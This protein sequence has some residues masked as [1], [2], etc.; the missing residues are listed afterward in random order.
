MA[1]E[2]LSDPQERAW[3]DSHRD[4]ILTGGSGTPDLHEYNVRVT[5]THDVLSFLRRSNGEIEFSDS[6][7]GFYGALRDFFATLARE[8]ESICQLADLRCPSYPSFGHADASYA[9]RVRAFYSFWTGFATNKS[10]SWKDLYRLS[11]APDRRV[12]RL[13]EKENKRTRDEAVREFNDAVRSL[14]AFAKKRDPRVPAS[15]ESEFDR[16]K[17]LR[18]ATVAQAIRSKLA[19]QAKISPINTIPD[20]TK[21]SEPADDEFSEEDFVSAAK[22][23]IECVICRKSFKSEKQ[24][25]AHER[26]KKVRVIRG[27]FFAEKYV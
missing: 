7:T 10:F 19:N 2:L 11:D 13:M 3:Y 23:I 20:W 6:P 17:V 4:F 16:Q 22:D 12:R 27:I 18:D 24:F 5:T 8:E 26:S 25:E 21:A 9:E 15:N 1:Y 14:V